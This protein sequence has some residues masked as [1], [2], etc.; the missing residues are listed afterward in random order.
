MILP[1]ISANQPNQNKGQQRHQIASALFTVNRPAGAGHSPQEVQTLETTFHKQFHSFIPHRLCEVTANHHEVRQVTQ[2]FL[3]TFPGPWLLLSGG[4]SGT[5]RAQIQAVM[6]NVVKGSI[7]PDDIYLGALRLGSGNIIPKHLGLPLDPLLALSKIA[8]GLHQADT[9]SCCLYRCVSYEDH[10]RSQTYYGATLVGIG[11]FGHIP[12]DVAQWRQRH[13]RLMTQLLNHTPLETINSWQ[14]IA[15]SLL[16]ALH[17]LIRP[18]RTAEVMIEQ[19]GRTRPL[20]LFSGLLVNFDFP[21]LPF[22]TGC[23]INEPQLKLCLI[24]QMKRR[25]MMAALSHW[26]SLDKE[27]LVYDITPKRPVDIHFLNSNQTT[28]AL[29]EDTFVLPGHIRFEVAPSIRFVTGGG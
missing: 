18:Q 20:R 29:D 14:Y 9:L 3:R 10:D 4:G 15:F 5:N 16:R 27:I 12:Q 13:P 28:L 25:Q 22:H 17:C 19:D 7:R 23:L 2:D 11:Q 1:D 24:P 21:Q 6:E 8:Q 26:R